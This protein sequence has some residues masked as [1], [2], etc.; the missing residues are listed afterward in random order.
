[1]AVTI[2]M[3]DDLLDLMT[4]Y[5]DKYFYLLSEDDYI[6]NT[7][8]GTRYSKDRIYTVH[9]EILQYAGIPFYGDKKGPRIHDWRYPNLYKIQTISRKSRV[10]S[11]S[12]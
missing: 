5:A 6:F 11:L 8:R 1:M 2:V 9:R 4:S 12:C 3:G 10:L 7:G